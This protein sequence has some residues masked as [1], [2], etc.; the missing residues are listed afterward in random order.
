MEEVSNAEP[1]TKQ[2]KKKKKKNIQT[3]KLKLLCENVCLS[4]CKNRF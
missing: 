4:T 2:I 3:K 1:K